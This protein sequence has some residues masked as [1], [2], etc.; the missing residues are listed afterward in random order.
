MRC[1]GLDKTGE[2]VKNVLKLENAIYKVHLKEK[3]KQN[4]KLL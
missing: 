1:W 4:K 2:T 3:T